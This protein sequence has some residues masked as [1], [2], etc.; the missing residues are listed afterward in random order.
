MLYSGGGM[1]WGR[2][3]V[4][5]KAIHPKPRLPLPGVG[6]VVQS[7]KELAQRDNLSRPE[8]LQDPEEICGQKIIVYLQKYS[9]RNPLESHHSVCPFQESREMLAIAFAPLHSHSIATICLHADFGNGL[10]YPKSNSCPG[11]EQN[12]QEIKEQVPCE[13]VWLQSAHEHKVLCGQ[14]LGQNSCQQ[15]RLQRPSHE[16][17]GWWEAKIKSEEQ[18]KTDQ[19]KCFSK[20]SSFRFILFPSSKLKE[21]PLVRKGYIKHSRF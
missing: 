17:K 11:Q 16:M 7:R 20:N 15:G 9:L 12:H 10:L 13:S 8:A 1:Q 18:Y 19:N 4:P 5:F 21:K 6:Q 14:S 3:Q 2:S